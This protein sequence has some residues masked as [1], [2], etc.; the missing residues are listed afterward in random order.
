MLLMVVIEVNIR[1]SLQIAAVTAYTTAISF[2]PKKLETHYQLALQY[3]W[4]RN[5]DKSI[6]SLSHALHQNK[7]HFPSI[8]LLMLILTALDD[9]E[10][11]LQTY[12]TIKLDH[13]HDLDVDEASAFMEIQLT[14][15]RIVEMVA[16][17][18]D[19]ALEVQKG[20]F[21]LYNC[22]FGPV[23]T[24][25]LGYIKKDEP[26][27]IKNTSDHLLQRARSNLNPGRGN[28]NPISSFPKTESSESKLSL[29]MP[30]NQVERKRSLLRRRVRSHSLDGRSIDSRSSTEIL[31]KFPNSGIFYFFSAYIR[32]IGP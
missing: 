13:I 20:A 19:L 6:S 3:A 23:A 28:L 24:S 30:I 27:V 15:L 21:K 10:K 25:P 12:H 32:N 18:R 29:Q 8:H 4:Q 5:L 31:G 22:I 1:P 11:A 17:G 9:Y 16:C 26:D 2:A 7:T 14:Y